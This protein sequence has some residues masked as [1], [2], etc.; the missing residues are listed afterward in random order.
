[1]AARFVSMLFTPFYLPIVGLI[2]LFSFSYLN[3]FPLLYKLE[4]LMLTYV[5]TIL[6]PTLL[7]HL[8]RRYQGWT[9]IELG[10]RERRMVPYVISIFC[11][12]ACV[13]IMDSVHMPHFMGS[14]IMAGLMVQMVCALINVWWKISTHTAAIGGVGGALFAFAEYLNFNPVWWL[15]V[16]FIIAGLLGTSRMILRQHSLGQVVGGFW[17]GFVC[18]AIAILFM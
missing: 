12:F 11:Y 3:I 4:V 8:Y 13:Y 7:I 16:I 10:H 9:L 6:L 15:C 14:I 1:M 17:V 2:A 18:A 5:L